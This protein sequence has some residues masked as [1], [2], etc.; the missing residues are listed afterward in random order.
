MG[1][2]RKEVALGEQPGP[3]GEVIGR[4]DTLPLDP[5][6]EGPRALDRPGHELREEGDEQR[7]VAQARDGGQVPAVD[8]EHVAEALERVEG[9]ADRQ[10]QPQQVRLDRDPHPRGQRGQAGREEVVVLEQAQH[11]EVRGQAEAEQA[12]AHPAVCPAREAETA[13]EV[14]RGR[15][16]EQ[17]QEP[18]VPVAV[19]DVSRREQEVVLT[20]VPEAQVDRVDDQEEDGEDPGVEDHQGRRAGRAARMAAQWRAA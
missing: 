5:G 20:L 13:E 4:D 10:G 3:R 15:Q 6:R 19:E 16:E 12:A 11:A 17:R 8:V 2:K 14:R 18:V 7:E 1:R 9:D